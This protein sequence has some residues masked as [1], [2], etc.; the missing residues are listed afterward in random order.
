VRVGRTQ[1][2]LSLLLLFFS[3]G[4][5]WDPASITE[6]VE[7]LDHSWFSRRRTRRQPRQVNAWIQPNHPRPRTS[8]FPCPMH[9][10]SRS[11]GSC[12]GWAS[13]LRFGGLGLCSRPIRSFGFWFLDDEHDLAVLDH[14]V[15]LATVSFEPRRRRIQS[16]CQHAIAGFVVEA[17]LATEHWHSP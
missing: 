2:L 1:G 16:V 13:R 15:E 3:V 17:D 11:F 5:I 14:V 4:G 12:F 10:Q 7:C 8:P 6:Q 9:A